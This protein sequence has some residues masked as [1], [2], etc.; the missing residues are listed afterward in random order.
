MW[1]QDV[2]RYALCRGF[3]RSGGRWVEHSWVVDGEDVIETTY[4]MQKYFGVALTPPEACEAWFLEVLEARSP[5]PASLMFSEFVDA[6]N[7]PW[8]AACFQRAA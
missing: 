7:R 5:G 1:A 2:E 3:A 4:R 8:P 6:A